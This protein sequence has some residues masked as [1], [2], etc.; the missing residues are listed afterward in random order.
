M[1]YPDLLHPEPLPLQKPPDDPYLCRRHK[2]SSGSISVGS[3]GPGAHSLF[4]PSE[5]LWQVWGLTL[6]MILPLLPSL[7]GFSFVLTCGVSFVGGILHS[8]VDGCSA[9]SCNFGVLTGEDKC[10]SFYSNILWECYF[11][12][13]WEGVAISRNWATAH[14]LVF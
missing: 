6:N 1:T 14:S 5:H 10:M 8:P 2:Y 3:L 13:F 7:W 12:Y 9:V 4:E 11:N